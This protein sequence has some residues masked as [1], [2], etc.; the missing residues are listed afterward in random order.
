MDKNGNSRFVPPT[1]QFNTKKPCS[2]DGIY[3]CEKEN[4]ER[5]RKYGDKIMKYVRS[6]K[7]SNDAKVFVEN[8]KYKTNKL[9]LEPRELITN[10]I[11]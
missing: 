6:V 11:F 3:F 5:W 10:I 7:I 9:I 1:N 2:E 8:K 4:I